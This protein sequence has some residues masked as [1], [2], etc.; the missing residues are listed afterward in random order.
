MK[1]GNIMIGLGVAAALAVGIGAYSYTA[2]AQDAG[3]GPG[4]MGGYGPG[5]MGGYGPGYRP[6]AETA[7]A[8]A[9]GTW[10]VTAPAGWAPA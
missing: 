8:P 7:T 6:M 4:M 3:Y 5:M 1:P 10:A 9:M 2:S